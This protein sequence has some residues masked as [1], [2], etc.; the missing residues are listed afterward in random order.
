MPFLI[1]QPVF[2]NY[3]LILLV[4]SLSELQLLMKT[5]IHSIAIAITAVFIVGCPPKHEEPLSG[6]LV[7]ISKSEHLVMGNPSNAVDSVSYYKQL[8]YG[9][10]SVCSLV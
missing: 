5:F 8:S 9:K 3:G 1:L 2:C 4:V 6:A 7:A 10:A